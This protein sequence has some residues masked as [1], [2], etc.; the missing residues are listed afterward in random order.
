MQQ[1]NTS[2]VPKNHVSIHSLDGV[3]VDKSDLVIL[4][5]PYERGIENRVAKS[6]VLGWVLSLL[7]SRKDIRNH[8]KAN[9]QLK[10]KLNKM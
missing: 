10:Q 1:S 2:D 8:L 7:L 4:D 5:S 9:F 6:K 3:L